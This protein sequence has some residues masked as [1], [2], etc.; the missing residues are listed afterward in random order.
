MY[1]MGRFV[2][3]SYDNE[4]SFPHADDATRE[5]CTLRQRTAAAAAAATTDTGAELILQ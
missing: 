5:L 4:S 1:C 2:R 3:P